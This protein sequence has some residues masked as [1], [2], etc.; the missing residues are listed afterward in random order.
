MVFFKEVLPN[1]VGEDAGGEW[2]KL[3]NTEEDI[4]SLAGWSIK[5]ASGKTYF[6]S[7]KSVTS[8]VSSDNTFSLKEGK[9]WSFSIN[10]NGFI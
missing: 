10:F 1:P 3:V 5:D 8:S 2:I 4:T 9:R 7:S 6:L